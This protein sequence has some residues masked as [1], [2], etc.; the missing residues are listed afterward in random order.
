MQ[1]PQVKDEREKCPAVTAE[2]CPPRLAELSALN[3]RVHQLQLCTILIR[4]KSCPLIRPRSC[5][6][7]A[8]TTGF[9][10]TAACCAEASTNRGDGGRFLGSGKP[11]LFCRT[12]LPSPSHQS[13]CHES[14]SP[15]L[16]QEILVIGSAILPHC[17]KPD[18]RGP[19][20]PAVTGRGRDEDR[21]HSG[22]CLRISGA[23]D[24]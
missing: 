15:T 3:S 8:T 14:S 2:Q 13:P 7:P 23:R 10:R 5:C 21:R 1:K 24:P 16:A 6:S 17:T 4:R 19:A 18:F 11:G 9:G 20:S 22:G 12:R